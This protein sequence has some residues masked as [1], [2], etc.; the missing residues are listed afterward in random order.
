MGCCWTSD[1]VE[2]ADL[3]ENKHN[4]VYDHHEHT[5]LFQNKFHNDKKVSKETLENL[6]NLLLEP[7]PQLYHPISSKLLDQKTVESVKCEK[8]IRNYQFNLFVRECLTEGMAS[9]YSTIKKNS[10]ALYRQ[11][12]SVVISTSK[13]KEVNL[14]SD[15]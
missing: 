7:K 5:E 13:Q 12:N 4:E 6:G 1:K 11:R 10:P 8:Y 3:F 14:S 15:C 9:L 2:T